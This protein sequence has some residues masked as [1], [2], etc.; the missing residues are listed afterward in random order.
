MCLYY[1]EK[2]PANI[3]ETVLTTDLRI[4]SNKLQS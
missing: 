4:N 1:R 3:A 2:R